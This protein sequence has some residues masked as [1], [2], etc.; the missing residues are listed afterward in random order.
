MSPAN[1]KEKPKQKTQHRQKKKITKTKLNKQYHTK[2][3]GYQEAHAGLH[4]CK[5]P[6]PEG[7]FFQFRDQQPS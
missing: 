3:Q 4:R 5:S 7:S 1:K 6:H 2:S